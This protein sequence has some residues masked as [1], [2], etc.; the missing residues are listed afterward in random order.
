MS[1]I[2]LMYKIKYGI[3]IP[4]ASVNSHITLNIIVPTGINI[5]ILPEQPLYKT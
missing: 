4:A 3:Y 1:L 5:S 2:I